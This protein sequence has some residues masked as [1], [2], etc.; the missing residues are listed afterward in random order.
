MIPPELRDRTPKSI[1]SAFR[2]LFIEKLEKYS[3]SP[4]FLQ[5]HD[6]RSFIGNLEKFL[7]EIKHDVHAIV[8]W[9]EL[10]AVFS[11]VDFRTFIIDE[12]S[13]K[14]YIKSKV[15]FEKA[16]ALLSMPQFAELEHRKLF[17]YIISN[18]E[19][20]YELNSNY[21]KLFNHVNGLIDKKNPK[22]KNSIIKEFLEEKT[23]KDTTD[24]T[25]RLLKKDKRIATNFAL[26]SIEIYNKY[27]NQQECM[28]FIDELNKMV[29][30]HKRKCNDLYGVLISM[31][32]F[33]ILGGI[34][35]ILDNFQLV[36]DAHY[37]EGE[38]DKLCNNI[39]ND[40]E[41]N[42]LNIFSCYK[43]ALDFMMS[44]E[45][46][47]IFPIDE[48][49]MT[50]LEK[51]KHD[52]IM[53]DLGIKKDVVDEIKIVDKKRKDKLIKE[54]EKITP[55]Y[56]KINDAQTKFNERIKEY[57][58]TYSKNLIHKEKIKRIYFS[59][60]VSLISFVEKLYQDNTANVKADVS[61][62][63]QTPSNTQKSPYDFYVEGEYF[64]AIHLYSKQ[65]PRKITSEN[66][67]IAIRILM[68]IGDCYKACSDWER[69]LKNLKFSQ[70]LRRSALQNYQKAL[71]LL[72]KEAPNLTLDNPEYHEWI[73]WWEFANDSVNRLSSLFNK[74]RTSPTSNNSPVSLPERKP[75]DNQDVKKVV[76]RTTF[77]NPA[78]QSTKTPNLE[79]STK[80][81]L[82]SSPFI[83]QEKVQP[84]YRQ[85]KKVLQINPF[86]EEIIKAHTEKNHQIY[87]VGGAVRDLFLERTPNDYDL[88]STATPDESKKLI[89]LE[90]IIVG[91]TSCVLKIIE[92]SDVLVEISP[93]REK[94]PTENQVGVILEDNTLVTYTP[95]KDLLKDAKHRDFSINT[96]IYDP[97]KDIVIDPTGQGLDD[98]KN[99]V[100]RCIDDPNESF[101]EDPI[102]MLRAVRYSMRYNFKM[103]PNTLAAIRENA[104]LLAGVQPARLLREMTKLFFEGEAKKSFDE[105]QSLNLLHYLLPEA[106][107]C[108][109]DSKKLACQFLIKTML[110][111][112]DTDVDPSLMD[113]SLLLAVMYW[114]AVEA[115][116]LDK[117]FDS[118]YDTFKNSVETVDTVLFHL[119]KQFG[120]QTQTINTIKLIWHTNL[121]KC[122]HHPDPYLANAYYSVNDFF[123]VDQFHRLMIM[124]VNKTNEA[125]FFSTMWSHKIPNQSV[126]NEVSLA[127]KDEEQLRTDG[128]LM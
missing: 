44:L 97:T 7:E 109:M 69:S 2:S 53:R 88:I 60:K 29:L 117:K 85:I 62:Q 25:S 87:V 124:A 84:K 63:A 5:A 96:L 111:A 30:D 78:T 50:T 10:G 123:I 68:S 46:K 72:N 95:T 8:G 4:D 101:Q 27:F 26:K 40:P 112:L 121:F 11:T 98:L 77:F 74:H 37:P 73:D 52:E 104:S 15:Y 91:K 19:F 118:P 107:K 51:Q 39:Q 94:T 106:A 14:A 86:V 119:E 110:N 93:M 31:S 120:L 103:E 116:L 70:Q 20:G 54:L 45:S 12:N 75:S 57:S 42:T 41:K 89:N 108:M 80:P 24:A 1:Y 65:L 128:L 114:S 6:L 22:N 58:K 47:R 125:L 76:K 18:G 48:N 35:A 9:L 99:G 100:I 34:Q 83:T 122:L 71:D 127:K 66:T 55:L 49:E 36:I 113:V 16:A 79:L 81:Q 92:D 17:L 21:M 67:L 3:K 13:T 28:N 33:L 23:T 38:I 59:K 32:T 64:K 82:Q 115:S 105:L 102:R 43:A 126:S 90:A 56:H 61:V